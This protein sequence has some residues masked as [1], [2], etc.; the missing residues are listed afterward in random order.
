MTKKVK[1]TN[2][3]KST[4]YTTLRKRVDQHFEEQNLSIYA[5]TAMWVKAI[6]FL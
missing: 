6:F 4:F 2:V 3:N 1:F 5:N